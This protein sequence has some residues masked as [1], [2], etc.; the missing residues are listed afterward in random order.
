VPATWL[1]DALDPVAVA[2]H[3]EP[4]ILNLDWGAR[5]PVRVSVQLSDGNL[6]RA[7]ANW[8]SA[9]SS[10]ATASP[11]AFVT[12][13][14]PG[15]TTVRACIDDW[16]CDDV[17][18]VVSGTAT[19]DQLFD[20]RFSGPIDTTRWK[21]LGK[22]APRTIVTEDGEGAVW[23]NGDGVWLDGLLGNETFALR[24]G[25]TAEIEFRFRGGLT[26]QDR[27]RV[28]LC[29]V[30]VDVNALTGAADQDVPNSAVQDGVCA[31][32]PADEL[33]HFDPE[34]FC[35]TGGPRRTRS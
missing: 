27:Q 24:R 21:L 10:I 33:R 13:N 14:Q 16:I 35:S 28:A 5:E 12:A 19:T 6:R 20:D 34:S 7:S 22:P 9:D 17:H 26:R 32:Y 25:T 11:E 8:S 4:D 15:V 1:E 23:L 2:V 30:Q 18:V 3:A 31:A 29:L